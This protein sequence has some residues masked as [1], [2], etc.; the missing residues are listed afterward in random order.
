MAG[1]WYKGPFI[2][3]LEVNTTAFEIKYNKIPIGQ[4]KVFQKYFTMEFYLGKINM[5]RR[6]TPL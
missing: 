4:E 6:K 5:G 3:I 2:L 1:P